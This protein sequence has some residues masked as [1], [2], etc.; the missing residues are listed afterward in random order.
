MLVVI[1]YPWQGWQGDRVRSRSRKETQLMM[2]FSLACIMLV[3]C[4][5]IYQCAPVLLRFISAMQGVDG[6][7]CD[8]VVFS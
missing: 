7:F 8:E 5:D 6:D 2:N 4:A 1:S 3:N